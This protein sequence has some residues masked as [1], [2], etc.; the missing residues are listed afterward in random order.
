V[1]FFRFQNHW[2][3]DAA[4]SRVYEALADVERYPRWWPQIRRARPI[5]ENSGEFICRSALPYSLKLIGSRE[6][7]DRDR[8]HLRVTLSGDLVGWSSW[9][10]RPDGAAAI[11]EF[12]QEVSTTGALKAAARIARPVLEWNHAVMMR[13]GQAGLRGYL[14]P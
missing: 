13:G 3:L 2:R 9:H 5:D 7:Q 4:A 1:A 10:I 6:V 8:M 14:S 11:A 12:T